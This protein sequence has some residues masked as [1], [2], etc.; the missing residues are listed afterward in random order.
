[1]TEDQLRKWL[2]DHG[3]QD[4]PNQTVYKDYP[5]RVDEDG[6]AI[7]PRREAVGTKI[8]AND[9]ATITLTRKN[10]GPEGYG[11]ENPDDPQ[12]DV[13]DYEPPKKST[14]AQKSP[15]Q[16]RQEQLQTQEA[17]E[18]WRQQ[19]QENNEKSWNLTDPAGSGRSETH[20][21][22]AAREQKEAVEARA[23][24][25]QEIQEEDRR[26]AIQAQQDKNEADRLDREQ[27]AQE[28]RDRNALTQQQIDIQRSSEERAAKKPDFLSQATDK[29]PYI[30]RY[31]PASGQ[32]V[33][34]ENP[35]YDAV[36][37]EAERKRQELELQIRNRQITLEEGKAAYSQWFD[38][39]V[40]TPLM[41]AQEARAKA[42]EQ[43][44]A[45]EAEERRRQFAADFRLR[46]ATLG[47]SAAQRA[48]N[49]EISLLPY[50]AGPTEAAEMSSAINSLA[51]GG[52]IDGPD[53]SA[54]VNF[55][56]GAFQFNAPDFDKIARNAA[57]SVLSG[58]TDYRPSDESYQ[59]ADYSGVPAVNTSGAPAL[60]A[61]QYPYPQ[62]TPE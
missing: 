42:E 1:M 20:A 29:N 12:Y 40:K 22:R 14:A 46:K 60:P 35:N 41:L 18:K 31:D 4:G 11:P 34:E 23:R 56:A 59:T 15:D 50:R 48:T 39:N 24:R 10:K 45:L 53:A 16:I 19:V 6:T 52:K 26:R 58:L 36:Q 38:T 44:Q 37:V 51:A 21:E 49:A 28:A 2:A 54:G 7:P 13:T 30:V 32:I 62:E 5:A 43:R 55:T 9:G 17:E 47:E 61:Y 27:R 8:T 3:G 25:D 57:K 33:K